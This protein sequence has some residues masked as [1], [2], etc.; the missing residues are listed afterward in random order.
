MKKRYFV[1]IPLLL[2]AAFI[3]AFLYGYHAKEVHSTK[4]YEEERMS[5]ISRSRLPDIKI[6]SDK[7]KIAYYKMPVAWQFSKNENFVVEDELEYFMDVED[8][9]VVSLPYGTEIFASYAGVL[10]RAY[11]SWLGYYDTDQMRQY[12]YDNLL[13]E[14]EAVW[15][16]E[17][18]E[19]GL[20]FTLPAEP[21]N[22][23]TNYDKLV[24]TQYFR[25]KGVHPTR[26]VVSYYF[27]VDLY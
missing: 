20:R 24:S 9:P 13:G 5:A 18:T 23:L 2:M 22:I 14:R 8:I 27:G 25:I 3:T 6:A 26:G 21:I 1:M 11:V 7:G 10:D 19:Q 15:P 12:V 4:E 17:K 16:T